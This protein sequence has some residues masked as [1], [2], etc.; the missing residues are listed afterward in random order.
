ME[1]F[2]YD[3]LRARAAAAARRATT[4]SSSASASRPSPRCA[5][6]PRRGCSGSLAYGAGGWE[7]A[8]DPDAA[9]RQ[10][11]GGHRVDPARPGPRDGVEPDRRRPARRRRSRTSRCCTATPRSRHKG[12]DTY[13]SR[14]L[15]VGGIARGQGRREGDREG[16]ADRRAPARGVRGRPR[17]HRRPRSASGARDKGVGIAGGRVRGV[18]RARPARRRGALARRRRDA[19][20]RR[21]SPSRTAPTC[22]R[23]RST[24]RPGG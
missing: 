10:G 19:T 23:W 12:M 17:V 9:D 6:W 14:S 15:A 2:G 21:T 20:T 13:G 24:P 18:R 8:G 3:E 16:Q 1:L 5:G 22:A 7:H 4:R 11:R